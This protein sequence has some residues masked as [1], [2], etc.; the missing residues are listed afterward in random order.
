M[1]IGYTTGLFGSKPLDTSQNDECIGRP[2]ATSDSPQS[3]GEIKALLEKVIRFH[4][5]FRRVW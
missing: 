3:T 2:A 5:G 4:G 1:I